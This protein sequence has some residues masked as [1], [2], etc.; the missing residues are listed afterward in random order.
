MKYLVLLAAWIPT[1]TRACNYTL[2]PLLATM[3]PEKA[4]RFKAML[5]NP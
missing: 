1:L 5:A 4:A 2:R 3:S